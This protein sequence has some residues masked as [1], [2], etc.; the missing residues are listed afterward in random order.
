MIKYWG[1]GT[2]R[3]CYISENFA[4]KVPANPSGF[5]CN[6]SEYF[7]YLF[8]DK[9]KKKFLAKTYFSIGFLNVQE[10]CFYAPDNKVKR[11]KNRA[12]RRFGIDPT[13]DDLKRANIGFSKL[14][15]SY[16]CIDYG[17]H[18]ALPIFLEEK[19]CSKIKKECETC[20]IYWC[21]NVHIRWE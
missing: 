20:K 16:V 18:V 8:A 3:K 2:Y 19:V 10:L 11:F 4:F 14:K 6:L 12:Y 21:R 17:N 9:K 13:F 5:L 15:N 7:I 1:R